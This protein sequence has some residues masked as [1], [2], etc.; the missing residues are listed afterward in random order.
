MMIFFMMIV[1]E[2]FELDI[3]FVF[4]LYFSFFILDLKYVFFI[5]NYVVVG[6]LFFIICIGVGV[7]VFIG[8][9]DGRRVMVNNV[10]YDWVCRCWLKVNWIKEK[11][12]IVDVNVW[13]GFGVVVVMD[14]V[15]YW[16]KENYG[17]DIM[18]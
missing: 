17:L 11:K 16:F 9:L 7:V 10:E 12:W 2:C 18:I 5:R 1:D 15:V 14:M 4:G 13:I 8:V 6:K 3:L